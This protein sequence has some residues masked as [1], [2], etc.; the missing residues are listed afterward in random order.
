MC[1]ICYV[2]RV[3]VLPGYNLSPNVNMLAE[4]RVCIRENME[5]NTSYMMT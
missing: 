3:F 4:L 5:Y 1:T 2:V